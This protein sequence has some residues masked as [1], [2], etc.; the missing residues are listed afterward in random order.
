[1][2]FPSTPRMRGILTA[3][4][5]L[6]SKLA[7]AAPV[8]V[9]DIL[10]RTVTLPAPA[11][12]IVLAESRHILTLALLS[13]DPLKNVV[14]WGSDLQRYSPSTF[15]A[16]KQ[17]F[18]QAATIQEIGDLNARTFSMEAAIASKPDLVVFTLYGAIPPDLNKLDAAHIP[19]V[20]VDFFR[21]PLKN[22][23]PSMLMLGKLL[24]H[25]RE[26]EKFVQFYQ[27]HMAAVAQRIAGQPQPLVFFHLNPGGE[28]CCFTSGKGNMNDFIAAAGGHNLGGDTLTAPVGQLNLE[29]V[30]GE[31]PDYYLA[32]G[33]STVSRHALRIGP[34][35]NARDSAQS[36]QEIVT[37]PGIAS[38]SAI[39][40]RKASGI[41]L[42][43]FDSPLYFLGVEAMAKMLH[44][45]QMQDI[46]PAQ[47][48]AQLNQ[49]FLAFPL[50]G[51][52]WTTL[53]AVH[54]RM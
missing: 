31:K 1:M 14:A 37:A 21:Q 7:C 23:A 43:F 53:P 18:P 42:F 40:Q 13:N 50:N 38:L 20:F 25:E 9:T 19:Y 32:G 49:Q 2:H 27:Q 29:Y 10:N 12:R 47:T 45:D 15:T 3:A 44:P 4:L 36:L 26:A 28:A 54:S 16:L 5:L 8:T 35:V 52:F 17:Q 34:A 46:D 39:Q 48:L 41:W 22:T 30:L 11:Q 6:L 51:S 24:G 33:G